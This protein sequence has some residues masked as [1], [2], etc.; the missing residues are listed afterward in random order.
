MDRDY[1]I[2]KQAKPFLQISDELNKNQVSTI[3]YDKRGLIEYFQF[4]SDSSQYINVSKQ[5][6]YAS[7]AQR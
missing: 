2:S 4:G 6:S 7:W 1:S 5:Y 3:R